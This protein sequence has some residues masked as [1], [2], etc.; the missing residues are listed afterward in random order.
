MKKEVSKHTAITACSNNDQERNTDT[1]DPTGFFRRSILLWWQEHRRKFPWR[2]TSDPYCLLIAEMMLRRTQARQVVPVYHT[3]LERFPTINDLAK[4]D[5]QEIRVLLQSLGL[6]WRARNF[7]RM[8]QQVV[9]QYGGAVPHDRNQL[10]ALEGVGDYVA[11]A[12][13][14]FAFGESEPL[15]DTNTV[16][17]TGRYLGFPTNAESRRNSMVRSAIAL[18]VEPTASHEANLALL[19]FAALVCRAPRPLCEQCPM[20]P[21]CQWFQTLQQDTSEIPGEVDG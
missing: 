5:E 13:R 19:D 4:A 8:A 20:T 7:L 10:L 11:T 17:V 6:A 12:V 9:E 18:L 2:D 14:C 21:H 1:L 3:F 16:R 15:I